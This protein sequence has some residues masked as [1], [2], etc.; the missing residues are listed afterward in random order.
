MKSVRM[1]N[2]YLISFYLATILVQK[3][4]FKRFE[5]VYAELTLP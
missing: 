3:L 5:Y 1:E 2:D 4:S